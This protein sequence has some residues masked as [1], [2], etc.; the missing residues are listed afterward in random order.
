MSVPSLSLAQTQGSVDSGAPGS[1]ITKITDPFASLSINGEDITTADLGGES[2]EAE[3]EKYQ[4]HEVITGIVS[5]GREI[6]EHA[7]VVEERLRQVEL[8]SVDDYVQEGDNLL[9][10]HDQ[11]RNCDAIL[12]SMEKLLGGFQS[13]LGNIS[14]EIRL[15]QEQSLTMSVKLRN[16]K[17]AEVKLGK[18]IEDLV[19][20][21]DLIRGILESEVTEDFVERLQLLDRKLHFVDKNPMAKEAVASQ[22]VKLELDRLKAKAVA[23]SR[24]FLLHK[25]LTLRKPKTNVQILQQNVLLKYNYLCLFLRSHAPEIYAEV[26]GTYVE[27]MNKVLAGHFRNYLQALQRLQLDLVTKGDLIGLE[28]SKSSGLFSR[29][30]ESLRNRGSVYVLGERREVLRDMEAPAIIPHVAES[31]GRKFPYEELFR[32]VNKLLLDTATSEYLFCNDFFGDDLAFR[33]L[34]A[35]PLGVVEESLQ[36]VLP[37]FHDAIGLLLMIRMTFHNQVIMSRRRIPCLDA[38]LD[39]INMMI[40]PRFKQVFDMHVESVRNVDEHTLVSDR[41]SGGLHPHYVTRRY[42]EFATSMTILNADYGDGQ[43]EQNMQRL[44]TAMDELLRRMMRMFK[45]RKR[46]TVFIVNN[47]DLIVSVMRES[48][49][50]K[51]PEDKSAGSQSSSGPSASD[52]T[53]SHFEQLL[54]GSVSAFVE[55]E[56]KES[57]GKL[58]EFVKLAEVQAHDEGSPGVDLS[59]MKGIL[60]DFSLRYS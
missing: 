32:S 58:I 14:S 48:G 8:E 25:F 19:I 29:S 50:A 23:K 53:R 60:A 10:L 7:K 46:Q 52:P 42:A 3:L 4:D 12:E 22:D 15:L 18:F 34:F 47:Y 21:P 2:L 26:Q 9:A 17:A 27:T 49:A 36:S 31:H 16:R 43:L 41:G 13:D 30:K 45:S 6:R 37:N 35:G 55:E 5:K 39:Q 33:D 51:D 20:P 56:L 28:E 24:E 44:R 57:M 38:Y 1:G 54:N 59:Y 40:W 11:V